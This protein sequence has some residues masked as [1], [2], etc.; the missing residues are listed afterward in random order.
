MPERRP[1][2]QCYAS[3]DV[4]A[5]GDVA[6]LSHEAF[7]VFWRLYCRAWN[8]E[9]LPNDQERLARWLRLDRE[10]FDTL[11]GE[12]S[13]LWSLKG[14]RWTNAEQE[15]KRERVTAYVASRSE[16]G[17]KGGRPPTKAH[18]KHMVSAENHM[19]SKPKAKK[20]SS[21]SS[22]TSSNYSVGDASASVKKLVTWWVDRQVRETGERPAD[23]AI[24]KQGRIAQRI[25]GERSET[26]IRQAIKGMPNL[27]KYSNGQ[28][29]DLFDLRREF[30][31]ALVA[32]HANGNGRKPADEEADKALTALAQRVT[33]AQQR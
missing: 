29:W 21:T 31:K 27:F 13:H 11:W 10:R 30:D 22:S 33:D 19:Q 4:L 8:E 9:G 12:M 3:D 6:E 26:S 23:S 20:S 1:A 24:S 7:G 16:N 32:A 5:N 28:T 15:K 25:C 17:K 2:F 14:E 18:E